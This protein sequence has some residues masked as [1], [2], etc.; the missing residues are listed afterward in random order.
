MLAR[1]KAQEAARLR[2]IFLGNMSHELRTP[3]NGVLGMIDLVADTDLDP[4]QQAYVALA[5]SSGRHLLT[6]IN[7]ILDF[8]KL[9]EGNIEII[10][11]SFILRELLMQTV[12]VF[13]SES[14]KKGVQLKSVIDDSLPEMII[15]DSTRIRQILVSLIGNALKFTKIGN[16]TV[17]A[18]MKIADKKTYVEFV[19]SDSGVGIHNE[20][21]SYIFEP[22]TQV[23]ESVTRLHGGAGLGL[24][25]SRQLAVAM[26][27]NLWASSEL[28]RGS[29]F[30][31]S[32]PLVVDQ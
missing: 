19:V 6:I 7:D 13:R 29:E 10:S 30:H 12:D 21:L 9:D 11:V 14:Q 27:G 22:F 28:G 25:I 1:D 31:F 2:S 32:I 3:L 23:D 24:A 5:G 26:G 4:E 15:G 16:V 8:S 18:R 17:T 20:Q